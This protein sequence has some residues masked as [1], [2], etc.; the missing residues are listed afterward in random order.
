MLRNYTN[1]TSC[2][3][4]YGTCISNTAFYSD[5]GLG[6]RKFFTYWNVVEYRRSNRRIYLDY[7]DINKRDRYYDITQI[8]ICIK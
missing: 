1:I 3:T 8:K 2:V 4:N 6:T 7:L 5:Y